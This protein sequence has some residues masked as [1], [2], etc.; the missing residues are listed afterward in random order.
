MNNNF[1]FFPIFADYSEVAHKREARAN[2]VEGPSTSVSDMILAVANELARAAEPKDQLRGL[3]LARVGFSLPYANRDDTIATL[4]AL[5]TSPRSK[6]P[7]LSIL[8]RAGEVVSA[9]FLMHGIRTLFED[10]KTE[11]WRLDNNNNELEQ[12]LELIPFLVMLHP[13]FWNFKNK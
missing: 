4:L 7:L 3:E 12:W 2:Q 8:V 6:L 1:R 5:P 13:D 9:D 10:A 11:R